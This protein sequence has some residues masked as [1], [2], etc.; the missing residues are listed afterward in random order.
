MARCACAYTCLLF[1][2]TEVLINLYNIHAYLYRYVCLHLHVH[3]HLM[4][5]HLH[6]NKKVHTHVHAYLH[7][8]MHTYIQT[9]LHVYIH[10]YMQTHTQMY[11]GAHAQI[12]TYIHV[13]MHIC[14]YTYPNGCDRN[15][16]LARPPPRAQNRYRSSSVADSFVTYLCRNKPNAVGHEPYVSKRLHVYM[17][18]CPTQ[19]SHVGARLSLENVLRQ[20]S[21]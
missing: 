21:C 20:C 3:V 15:H 8:Y 18:R 12:H 7:T 17:G 9:L 10:T 6:A 5:V 13:Y 4:H 2:Y 16:R 1:A 19:V 11:A 14:K